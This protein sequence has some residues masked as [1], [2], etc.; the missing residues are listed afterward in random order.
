MSKSRSPLCGKRVLVTRPAHQSEDFAQALRDRGAIPVLAPA[1]AMLPPDDPAAAQQAVNAAAQ[2]AWVV[3]TSANG[4]R[5]FL[6]I[7]K[8]RREDARAFGQAKIAAIGIKTSQ[9]LLERNIFADLVP[10]SYVAE[11][12]ADALVAASQ[13]GDKILIYRAEEARDV[14]PDRLRAT[15]REPVVVSAY[16]TVYA[17]D[18]QYA[19]KVADCD[20]LTFTSA[21]TVRGFA[22]NLHGNAAA[23]HAA[24]GKIVACIGP[25]TADEARKTGLDVSVVANEF[26]ADGLLIALERAIAPA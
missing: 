22:H 26:T 2:Y 1:I 21:S 25:V 6:N 8:A 23:A 3:F 17:E 7:L 15:G 13:P 12:L 20:I 14:L 19:E 9:A 11:H 4:V 10:Q 5:A 24:R 16:K 18:P